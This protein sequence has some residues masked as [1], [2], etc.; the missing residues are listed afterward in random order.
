MAFHSV[1]YSSSL[2]IGAALLQVTNVNDPIV[3]TTGKGFIV[4]P[5]LSQLAMV[6]GVGVN[7]TRAQLTSGSI[8][9]MFPWDIDRMNVGT[10]IESPTRY[11]DLTMSPFQLTPYEELDAFATQSNAAAQQASV[12]V[13]LC[14]GPMRPVIGPCQTVHATSSTT[15]VANAWTACTMVLDNGLDGGT[16]AIVGASA[17]SADGQ[18]FRLAPRGGPVNRPGGFCTQTR[19][20]LVP[21]GQRYGGW[22]QWMQFQNL[23][24][25]QVEFFSA[26]ADTSEEV[27]FDLIKVG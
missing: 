11:T 13:T 17:L 27:Y 15:L 19:D 24:P 8:R 25:P 14:D 9:K 20:G 21:A 3:A 22:G 5:T 26:A 12:F 4:P 23:Q 7:L 1:M 10:A 2:A 6:A 16:Y 18:F